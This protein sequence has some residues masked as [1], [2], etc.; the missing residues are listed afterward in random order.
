MIFFFFLFF[1]GSDLRVR[2]R[3]RNNNRSTYACYGWGARGKWPIGRA[4]ASGRPGTSGWVWV[5][6][7]QARAQLGP[8]IS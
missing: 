3:Q 4:N 6:E 5:D 2:D 1:T 7:P 8:H